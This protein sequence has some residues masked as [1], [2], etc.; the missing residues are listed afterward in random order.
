MPL[1]DEEEARQLLSEWNHTATEYPQEKRVEDLFAEQVGQRAEAIALEFGNERIS[2]G[3]L[4]GRANQLA[5]HLRAHGVGAGTRVALCME[6]SP[7][8]I[9][10]ML[11]ILKAGGVYVPLDPSYP[12]ERLNFMI[13]DCEAAIALTLAPF[14]AALAESGAKVIPWRGVGG[15][16]RAVWRR[17]RPA[18]SGAAE[19]A[20]VIYT[21]GSTGKPKGVGVPHRAITRL[22]A[23]TNYI[24]L[25]PADAVAHL[26]QVCFDAATFEI[27]G[28]L[29][30][31]SRLVLI[32]KEVALEPQLF[33]SALRDYGVS[34]LF[35]T[36]ALFNELAAWN[37]RI[38]QGIK[39][40]LFGGEAVNL[41]GSSYP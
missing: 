38:F 21:S 24:E 2:Y 10:G 29:C 33:A 16:R 36:T 12:Q 30:N 23:N 40:V 7:E 15:G 35:L 13:G 22:V 28:A 18:P 27:W 20:Y 41:M 6:R 14:A 26:S 39:Q 31:G 1:L 11:G 32:P 5:A 19:L 37:G 25:G 3:E 34:T 4:D 9:Y 17:G 8:M